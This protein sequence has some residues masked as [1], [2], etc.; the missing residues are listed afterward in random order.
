MA[1]INAE[2]TLQKLM[3]KNP[4]AS[5]VIHNSGFDIESNILSIRNIKLEPITCYKGA[6][7]DKEHYV[8]EVYFDLANK[9]EYIDL[10][11]LELERLVEQKVAKTEFVKAIVIYPM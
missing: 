8:D 9:P 11:D 6:W 1:M 5:V 7:F 10:A 3:L 2:Y 4:D